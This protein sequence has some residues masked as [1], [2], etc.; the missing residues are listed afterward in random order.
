MVLRLRG[1]SAP[2][3]EILSAADFQFQASSMSLWKEFL[4]SMTNLLLLGN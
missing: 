1:L 2:D 4:V 3:L